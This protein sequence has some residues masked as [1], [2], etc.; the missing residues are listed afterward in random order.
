[1]MIE[2][3][4]VNRHLYTTA[5][6]VGTLLCLSASAYADT[7]TIPFASSLAGGCYFGGITAG[8]VSRSGKILNGING[9]VPLT[10][11]TGGT[12]S[13]ADPVADPANP[14]TNPQAIT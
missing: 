14:N 9:G 3:A 12:L 7:A 6:A 5:L 11:T 13:V 4:R 8:T 1:M 10:C 2:I